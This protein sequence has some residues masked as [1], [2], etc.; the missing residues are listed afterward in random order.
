VI[1]FVPGIQR[2]CTTTR[3][4]ARTMV[5]ASGND[6]PLLCLPSLPSSRLLLPLY[7]P[8]TPSPVH[9]ASR[10]LADLCPAA[11]LSQFCGG[12]APHASLTIKD[13]LGI[14]G[15]A[16][17][18]E[19]VLEIPVL[20]VEAVRCSRDGDVERGGDAT[21]RVELGGFAGVCWQGK[22]VFSHPMDLLI[23][24]YV[25]GKEEW[26]SADQL[27]RHSPWGSATASGPAR[28]RMLGSDP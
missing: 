24:G 7:T 6:I 2:I 9:P 17:K 1:C 14:F 5:L 26:E 23:R 12:A 10:V 19:S 21:R 11:V 8:A 15:R 3:R 27:C 16:H 13:K 18:A 20:D 22:S 25:G 4:H 28:S